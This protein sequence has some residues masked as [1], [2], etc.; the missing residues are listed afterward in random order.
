LSVQ[1][2]TQTCPQP[3]GP[4]PN[5]PKF[6]VAERYGMATYRPEVNLGMF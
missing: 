1:I 3:K 5:F 2:L 4:R 6:I